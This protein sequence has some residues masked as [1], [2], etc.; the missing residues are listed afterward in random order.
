MKMNFWKLLIFL[1]GLGDPLVVPVEEALPI[2]ERRSGWESILVF[3]TATI[4]GV[5]INKTRAS[6]MGFYKGIN[7]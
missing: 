2:I 6:C 7:W 3:T 1:E 4:L 5:C